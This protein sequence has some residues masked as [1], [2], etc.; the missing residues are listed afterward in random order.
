MDTL[1][2]LL[3]LVGGVVLGVY[4]A[5]APGRLRDDL[6]KPTNGPPVGKPA[7]LVIGGA[8]GTLAGL[9]GLL[10]GSLGQ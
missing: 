6:P 1:T 4:G 8:I 7:W 3:I 10:H 2:S 9:V 5:S